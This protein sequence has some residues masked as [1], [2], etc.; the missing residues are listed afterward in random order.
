MTKPLSV[1]TTL[2]S[3]ILEIK[4][5]SLSVNGVCDLIDKIESLNLIQTPIYKQ[6]IKENNIN[7]RVLLHCDLQELKKVFKMTFGDWELFRMVIVS[8]REMELSSFTYE[9]GPRSV[10]FTV[11]SEQILRKDHALPNNSI[12]VSAHVEKEKGASRTDGSTRRDQNKQSIMEKQVTLEEQMICGALQT[13]NEEACEDVLDV[14]SPAVAPTTDSL[15]SGPVISVHDT[16]YVLLQ[17]SPL[18]HWVPINDEPGS[19][20][21]SSHDSTMFLQRT[22]SQRSITSQRSTRSACSHKTLKRSGSNISTRP[23]SL[24][25]SPPSSPKPAIRS[26][27]TDERCMGKNIS[28]KITPSSVS[29]KRR[30]SSTFNDELVISVPTSSLEKLSRLKDR[31]IG[32]AP[33]AGSPATGGES[34]DESTPLVS[35]MSTPTHSQSDSVFKHD[36][37]AENSSSPSSNRSLPRDGERRIDLDYSDTVS[38]V[39]RESSNAQSQSRHNTKTRNDTE[40]PV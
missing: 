21:D 5:S 2:P 7:G 18:F 33:T 29:I 34:D 40:T 12:R 19:S 16:E 38:L 11:G 6:A 22:N 3:E 10:R 32:T 35:E 37:S 13:L 36:C 8:L 24:F 26:K 23:S 14:P 39:I 4:L 27:S 1:T 30:S 20:D 25:I 17:A 28:Q 31:L 15:S 9:E